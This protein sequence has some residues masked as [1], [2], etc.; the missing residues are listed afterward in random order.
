V[1]G[2]SD[3]VAD[4]PEVLELHVVELDDLRVFAPRGFIFFV[5]HGR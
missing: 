1:T 5:I 2:L 4:R 3:A